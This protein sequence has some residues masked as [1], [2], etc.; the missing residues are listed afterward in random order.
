MNEFLNGSA[1]SIVNPETQGVDEHR[2]E[3]IRNFLE[4]QLTALFPGVM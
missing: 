2:A 3:S 4:T 1:E